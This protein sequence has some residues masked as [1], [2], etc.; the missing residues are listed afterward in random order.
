MVTDHSPPP[1]TAAAAAPVAA[2]NGGGGGVNSP[3]SQ[4]RS[5][6]SPW[7]SV[8]RGESD[9][10]SSPTAAAAAASTPGVSM[11]PPTENASASD[12]SVIESS[13]SEAQPESSDVNGDSNAGRPRRPAWN[14]PVNGVV[15]PGSVMGGAVSWPA[16]SESTRPVPRSSLDNSRPVVDG[17]ASPSQAPIISQPPQ[18]PAN[19]NAHA[20]SN[21]NNPMPTRPRSRNRGGG[22]SGGGGSSSGGG[23][24]QN[25]FNRTSPPVPPPF[26]VFDP[27]YGVAPPVLDTSVRG[28]RPVGGVGGSQSPT[29]NDHSSPRN[30]SR[31]GNYGPRPRGDGTFHNNHGGRRDQDRRDVPLPPQ[32]VPPPMGYMPPPPLPPGAPFIAPQP[33]RVFPGPMGFDMPP[34]LFYVPAMSPESFRP[35]PIVPP[36]PPPMPYPIANENPLTNLIVKQIDYYFSD[37]NLVKDNFLR[38][39]MDDNGWVLISLIA[40]FRRV[41]QL[42]ND[43]QVILEAL[44]FSAIVEVQGEKLRRRDEWSKWLHSSGRVNSDSGSHSPGAAPENVLATSV[45]ELSLDDAVANANGNVEGH[46]EMAT[47]RVLPEE[48]TGH[49]RLANGEDTAEEV[50]ISV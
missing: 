18:R 38:S 39:N 28:A 14:R 1:A 23:P 17:S 27:T 20:N 19:N 21:A 8:V 16:L 33:V 3:Q 5:L 6:P 49:S 31:R 48:L 34:P 22:G 30:N 2:A 24:S 50:R 13:G 26:P 41:Q 35:V 42:T 11:S 15:E 46:T 12:N 29:G 40:S 37:D 36:V 44:K 10:I 47:G 25:T 45:Q 32:Y 9:Q 43:I 7:A 4:R